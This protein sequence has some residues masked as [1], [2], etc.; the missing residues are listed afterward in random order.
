M[1]DVKELAEKL[2]ASVRTVW[3]WVSEGTLPRPV[4]LGGCT[5]WFESD[6]EEFQK[7]LKEKRNERR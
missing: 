1:L 4:Q 5:R 7:K 2:R 6:I 3:R